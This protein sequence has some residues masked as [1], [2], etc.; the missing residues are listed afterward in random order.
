EFAGRRRSSCFAAL[1]ETDRLQFHRQSDGEGV[2]DLR[3]VDIRC[4]HACSG[5]R[6]RGRLLTAE[7]HQ[8]GG[9]D[10]MFVG[11]AL[12]GTKYLNELTLGVPRSIF[13]AYHQRRT[14]V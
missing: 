2:I 11:M 12:H 14:T 9:G 10:D 4:F 5:E 6:G 13:A 3:D 8:A 1:E 7:V